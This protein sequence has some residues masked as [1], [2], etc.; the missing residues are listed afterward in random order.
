MTSKRPWEYPTDRHERLH[1][2]LGYADYRSFKPWLRDEFRFRCVYCLW[3]EAWCADGD[4][5]FG[6]DHVRPRASYPGQERDYDNLVYACCR[7]N[8]IKQDSSLPTDPCKEG[9]GKHLRVVSD[10]SV[11]GITEI[12]RQII[13]IC[14][15]NRAALV[16][17]RRR[18]RQLL[19]ELDAA[20]TD[21]AKSLLQEYLAFPSN[22]PVLSQLNPPGGNKRPN[23]IA[24]SHH[25][26]RMRGELQ[27]TY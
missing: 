10:G 5:S 18:M 27:E 6:V 23:G 20:K 17:A 7:C 22:L 21:E 4:G 13:E 19:Q 12:G 3:R 8:S 2:P 25:E 24:A 16:Q 26:L 9:L 1:G 15:L 14:R 11:H